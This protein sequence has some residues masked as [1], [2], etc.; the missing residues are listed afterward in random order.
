MV[1]TP[2]LTVVFES[3]TVCPRNL[4]RAVCWAFSSDPQTALK[5]KLPDI[6]HQDLCAQG[7]LGAHTVVSNPL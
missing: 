1:V 6:R 4:Q 3:V 7:W 5:L 2:T